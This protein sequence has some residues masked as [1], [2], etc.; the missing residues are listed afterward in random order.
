MLDLT[1]LALT[2][3]LGDTVSDSPLAL[4]ANTLWSSV[5][6]AE[7][8]LLHNTKQL[9]ESVK[10]VTAKLV[11]TALKGMSEFLPNHP[12]VC[13]WAWVCVRRTCR[14]A[15]LQVGLLV[16]FLASW[17][18]SDLCEVDSQLQPSSWSDDLSTKQTVSPVLLS[19]SPSCLLA[20]CSVSWLGD[21]QSR[22]SLRKENTLYES[23]FSYKSLLKSWYF[24]LSHFEA[25]WRGCYHYIWFFKIF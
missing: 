15:R 20:C 8:H 10:L 25:F 6:L 13:V 7:P 19:L 5:H 16:Q 3:K 2:P 1:Y 11:S 18:C 23:L 14:D 22:V 21:M 24:N 4:S 17:H 12:G 9:H